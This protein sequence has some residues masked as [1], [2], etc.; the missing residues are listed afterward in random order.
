MLSISDWRIE[1][2]T[3]EV[4]R[5]RASACFFST[6]NPKLKIPASAMFQKLAE[7]VSA[8]RPTVPP[9]AK[10][11]RGISSLAGGQIPLSPP[12]S[13]G[14]VGRCHRRIPQRLKIP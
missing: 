9:L 5:F 14:D 2:P 13:K 7:Y 8:S 1:K 3:L 12:F 4:E 10:G 6:A 11:V